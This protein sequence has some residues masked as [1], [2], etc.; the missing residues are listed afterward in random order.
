MKKFC[1]L[2]GLLFVM[3]SLSVNASCE[4]RCESCET[5]PVCC[6]RNNFCDGWEIV[7]RGAGVYSTSDRFKEIYSDWAPEVQIELAK[8]VWNNFYGWAN[9]AYLWKGGRSEPFHDKTDVNLIPITF[10]IKYVLP[11]TCDLSAY[12]GGGAAYTILRVKDHSD[13]NYVKKHSN[14]YDWG[15]II[16]SGVHYNIS[17]SFFIDVFVDYLFQYFSSHSSNGYS[18]DYYYGDESN[19]VNLSG[20]RVGGGLGFC[21]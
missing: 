20:L 10:G 13:Y 21:F 14:R 17:E 8:R 2:F 11:I 9:V 16:K 5:V 6:E 19:G 12:I 4:A 3:A 7:L 18:D 15:G 1:I